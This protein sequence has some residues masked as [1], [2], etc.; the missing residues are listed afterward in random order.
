MKP[1]QALPGRFPF[2]VYLQYV[3]VYRNI[4]VV[5]WV[6]SVKIR[7]AVAI[8]IICSGEV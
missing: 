4:N 5:S 6:I 8:C 7:Q 1:S 3:L 2:L